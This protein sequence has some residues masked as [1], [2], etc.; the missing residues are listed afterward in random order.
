MFDPPIAS[1]PNTA[2]LL[3]SSLNQLD[4]P[5]SSI[6]TTL[7]SIGADDSFTS[8]TSYDSCPP[9]PSSAHSAATATASDEATHCSDQSVGDMMVHYQTASFPVHGRVMSHYSACFATHLSFLLPPSNTCTR[10]SAATTHCLTLPPLYT[11][12]S[13]VRIT[14]EQ[15]DH[16]LCQLHYPTHY[17]CP[18]LSP[19]VHI[20]LDSRPPSQLPYSYPPSSLLSRAMEWDGFQLADSSTVEAFLT[21]VHHFQCHSLL[22]HCDDILHHFYSQLPSPIN[23][24][25]AWDRLVSAHCYELVRLRRHCLQL[26]SRDT[27]MDGEYEENRLTLK[28]QAGDVLY[29]QLMDEVGEMIVS[30]AHTRICRHRTS[31]GGREAASGVPELA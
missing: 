20:E 1:V 11:M 31:L 4:L 27:R 7:T 18:P 3:C 25:L 30:R 14:E 9:S 17:Y 28:R 6:D 26:V 10:C 15:L 5:V 2:L 21:L 13:R 12:H 19:P 24:W 16:F 22:A 8:T 23:L 29:Q